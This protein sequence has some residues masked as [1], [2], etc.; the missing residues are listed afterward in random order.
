MIFEDNEAVIKTTLEGR[1]PTMRHLTRTHR[2]DL[3]WLFERLRD[4]PNIDIRY[5]GTKQQIADFLTKG[6]VSGEQWENLC[7]LAQIGPPRY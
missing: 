3:D 4:D 6:A 5:V 1:P 2:I 7:K